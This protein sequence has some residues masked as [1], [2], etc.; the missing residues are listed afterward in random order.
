[1]R[2]SQAEK[3]RPEE[4][5]KGLQKVAEQ[6]NSSE[7]YLALAR[8]QSRHGSADE[9]QASFTKAA[10]LSKAA[11]PDAQAEALAALRD[12]PLLQHRP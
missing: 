1:M 3:G 11:T 5:L 7:A 9:A 2:K 8:F 6:S 10:E 12:G 4:G